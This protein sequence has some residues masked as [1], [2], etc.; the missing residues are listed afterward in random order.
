M[1][2]R[3][4]EIWGVSLSGIFN[5]IGVIPHSAAKGVM[6]DFHAAIFHFKAGDLYGRH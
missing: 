1:P 4:A 5:F 3:L 2:Q 6:L